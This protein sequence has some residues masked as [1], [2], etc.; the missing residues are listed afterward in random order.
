MFRR[1]LSSG[2]RRLLE[3]ICQESSI[4]QVRCK[5]PLD[6]V[7]GTASTLRATW[8][9]NVVLATRHRTERSEIVLP[10]LRHSFPPSFPSIE[11]FFCLS[12][13]HSRQCSELQ[14]FNGTECC[15]HSLHLSDFSQLE[16]CALNSATLDFSQQLPTFQTYRRICPDQTN[17]YNGYHKG[18]HDPSGQTEPHTSRR[19]HH[20]ATQQYD[21]GECW[22][23][24][25][26]DFSARRV[27]PYYQYAV[28]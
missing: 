20:A 19:K 11:H 15:A 14:Q 5:L 1:L 9:G 28:V 25:P 4:S 27:D 3:T 12:V 21:Q 2:R 13:L 24:P 16:D 17:D 8:D 7:T 18:I 6:R 26:Q 23:H 10:S 22:L